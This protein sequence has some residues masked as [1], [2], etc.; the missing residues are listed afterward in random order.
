MIKKTILSALKSAGF[1]H[2]K[3]VKGNILDKEYRVIS[4]TIRSRPD[5]DDAWLFT[6]SRECKYIF[7]IGSNIGQAAIM[8]LYHK[9]I[10]KIILVDPNPSALSLAAENIIQNNESMR[11]SF[12]TA[13]ISDECDQKVDFYTQDSG[14]AGSKF[15]GFAKTAAK[16]NSHYMV[17]TL[18]V[19]Y[20]SEYFDVI[21]DLVKVDV[22]GAERDV[23]GGATKLASKG[24]TL[25]FVE[26]HSGPELSI[27]K[28]T[29]DIIDWCSKNNYNAW[30]LKTKA[31][32]TVEEIQSRGRYHAL[33]I[34]Q[35]NPFPSILQ[36]V[37]ENDS[38]KL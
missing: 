20:L 25:F 9:G 18:T 38:L 7:D 23:L 30:Y 27:T 19:D 6:L 17:N 36:S 2:K 13:F 12:V 26:I 28:N 1:T 34:P 29:Q 8:M 16:S 3:W 15:K 22:E 11:V 35:S 37:N 24:K 5:K 10:N 21:P 32:L 4:N 33:L 14:A 31:P